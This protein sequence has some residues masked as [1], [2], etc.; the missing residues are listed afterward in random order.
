[1]LYCWQKPKPKAK[2]SKANQKSVIQPFFSFKFPSSRS[3]LRLQ[4]AYYRF[5]FDVDALFF[6][7]HLIQKA[8][9]FRDRFIEIWRDFLV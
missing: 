6:I 2:Q 3:N 8:K 4:A 9:D 5:Y 7:R 1:M